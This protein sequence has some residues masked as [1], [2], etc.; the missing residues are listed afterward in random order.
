MGWNRRETIS[1]SFLG[2][3]LVLSIA[4]LCG[5]I[6]ATP[7]GWSYAEAKQAQEYQGNDAMNTNDCNFAFLFGL[8]QYEFKTCENGALSKIW[9]NYYT[10]GQCG[11]QFLAF[12]DDKSQA[13][14]L[15]RDCESAGFSAISLMV[16]G[17]IAIVLSIQGIYK[18]G[19]YIAHAQLG[20][21]INLGAAFVFV[22]LSWMLWVFLCQDNLKSFIDNFAA[23]DTESHLPRDVIV[24]TGVILSIISTGL[25]MLTFLVE[26]IHIA[27]ANDSLDKGPEAE[28]DVVGNGGNKGTGCDLE[29]ADNG[30]GEPSV[31]KDHRAETIHEDDEE[32]DE[33]SPLSPGTKFVLPK[34]MRLA[35]D[36]H[37]R[38]F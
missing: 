3:S 7:L 4:A 16:L 38:D 5:G 29:G 36:E 15:C 32:E 8:V 21:M 18:G 9:K 17:V 11:E 28:L 19:E 25:I 35:L 23:K 34:T 10:D 37:R 13:E 2:V 26:V 20:I 14:A 27:E 22:T 12:G 31:L 33:T 1:I 24:G 30:I 6:F